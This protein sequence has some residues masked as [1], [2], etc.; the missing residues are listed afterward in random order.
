MEKK[1]KKKPDYSGPS[2]FSPR[3]PLLMLTSKLPY[4]SI[5]VLDFALLR[6]T[7]FICSYIRL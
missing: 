5:L 3:R 1:R 6:M 4:A 7:I 2:F